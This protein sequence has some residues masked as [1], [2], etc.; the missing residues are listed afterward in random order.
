MTDTCSL[1]SSEAALTHKNPNSEFL[2]SLSHLQP[3]AVVAIAT[4][5]L[6]D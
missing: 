4:Q 2:L 3:S 5:P 6:K 1:I